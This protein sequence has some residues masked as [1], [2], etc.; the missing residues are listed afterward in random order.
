MFCSNCGFKLAETSNFCPQCGTKVEPISIAPAVPEAPAS[1]SSQAPADPMMEAP[2]MEEPAPTPTP[3]PAVTRPAI[4]STVPLRKGSYASQTIGQGPKK[5]VRRVVRTSAQPSTSQMRVP[6][7]PL[8][9]QEQLAQY[10]RLRPSPL[11][12]SILATILCCM[13]LGVV[14]IVMACKENSCLAVYDFTGAAEANQS[15]RTWAFWA[16]ITSIIGNGISF[17]ILFALPD[18]F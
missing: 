1:V 4:P 12:W 16:L 9:P 15:A 11:V 7:R 2:V 3:A 17:F 8:T 6:T 14:S 5:T 13:P 10:R 18:T